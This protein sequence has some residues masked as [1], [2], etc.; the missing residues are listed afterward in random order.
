MAERPHESFSACPRYA[1]SSVSLSDFYD[2]QHAIECART[3]DT[4]GEAI[5]RQIL[6]CCQPRCER[7]QITV[8]LE[9]VI[10]RRKRPRVRSESR[11]SIENPSISPEQQDGLEHKAIKF[12][13]KIRSYLAS[14]L[15]EES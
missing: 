7:P 10:L 4:Q 8:P 5:Q 15:D 6:S 14:L 2:N 13:G 12:I 3:R 1:E 11:H 9:H